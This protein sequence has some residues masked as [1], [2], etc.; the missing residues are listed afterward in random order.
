MKADGLHLAGPE[1][2][3]FLA[4]KKKE[5]ASSLLLSGTYF[6]QHK[7]EFEIEFGEFQREIRV[8]CPHRNNKTP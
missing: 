8:Q 2:A 5:G 3:H 4:S 1:T 6:I 7:N